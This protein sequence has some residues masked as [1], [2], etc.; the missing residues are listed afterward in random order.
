MRVAVIG[1]TGVLGSAVVRE[2]TARGHEVR[3]VSRT[4]PEE[5]TVEHRAADLRTGA[6]LDE[7]LAGCEAVVNAANAMTKSNAVLV[8]GVRMLLDAEQRAGVGHH[9]EISIV[10]CDV[11]PFGYYRTKVAQEQV[12]TGGPVPWTLLRATQFH[13]LIADFVGLATRFHLAPRTAAKTQP[14]DVDVVAARMVEAVAAGPS[15]RVPD[16]GG[17]EVLTFADAARIYRAHA[18][19]SGIPVPLPIPGAMGRALR[20][21][22]L[23]VGPDGETG[24]IGFAEWLSRGER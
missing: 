2:A 7:A 10:G 13:H 1:G 17:P 18:G 22:G 4:A 19:R 6:G 9:V 12:V 23:C 3:V 14:I 16:I 24:G 20:A 15:G 5:A 8:D 11:V 21:G